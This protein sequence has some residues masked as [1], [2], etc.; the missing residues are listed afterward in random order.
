MASQDHLWPK[1]CDRSWPHKTFKVLTLLICVRAVGVSWSNYADFLSHL[2]P[3]RHFPHRRSDVSPMR[4]R[5]T[6]LFRHHSNLW[7][8]V[9]PYDQERSGENF[10]SLDNS[11]GQTDFSLLVR[12]IHVDMAST[13]VRSLAGRP[14]RNLLCQCQTGEKVQLELW[15]L[16]SCV[17]KYSCYVNSIRG[18]LGCRADHLMFN[19][20]LVVNAP[21]VL[22][23]TLLT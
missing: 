13:P 22:T 4:H 23:K 3:C 21:V 10:V 11:P 7:F 15:C 19:Q 16:D 6:L 2:S 1:T 20:L 14:V 12:I 18:P 17:L 5:L 9:A 8:N